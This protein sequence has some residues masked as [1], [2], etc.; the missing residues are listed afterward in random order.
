[1]LLLVACA[2]LLVGIAGYLAWA[3]PTDPRPAPPP[4]L[5]ANVTLPVAM[6]AAKEFAKGPGSA[7]GVLSLEARRLA[8]TRELMTWGMRF[9]LALA[10]SAAAV[11]TVVLVSP[12]RQKR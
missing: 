5:D 11:A 6:E 10:A 3:R 8:K 1:M 2:I 7:A 12:T 9:A 4:E